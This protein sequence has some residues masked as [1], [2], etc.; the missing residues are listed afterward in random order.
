MA[1]SAIDSSDQITTPP[2]PVLKSSLEP[3][4]FRAELREKGF[5]VTKGAIPKDR[6]KDYQHKAHDWLLSFGKGL[7][8]DDPQTWTESNLPLTNKIRVYHGY[9]VAHEKFMWDARMEHGFLDAFSRLW[10]TDE[11]LVSFDCLNI[12]LPNRPDLPARKAWEH[13]DQSPMK[14]GVHCVQGI[15]NLS[16]NGPEDEGLVVYPGSHKL[17]DEFF[18]THPD[19]ALLPNNKDVY[20][21]SKEECEATIRIIN[22]SQERKGSLKFHGI[23]GNKYQAVREP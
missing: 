16:P 6:A 14:R 4:D 18:D 13:I 19:V 11:L 5:C 7:K 21:F 22:L 2:I 20:L 3:S 1:P 10:G 9:F 23:V 15:I 12:T 8:L 17:N